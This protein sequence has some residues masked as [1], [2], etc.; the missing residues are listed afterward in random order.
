MSSIDERIVNMD[1]RSN[2][3]VR[4][5]STVL[6]ML[7]K[8]K[9]SLS[10]SGSRNGIDQVQESANRFS[11]AGMQG[12]IQ[13]VSAGFIALSTVAITALSNIVNRAVDAGLSFA[14][15][16]TIGPV[17]D[18]LHE[19]ETNLKSIQTVQA[20]TDRPLP[21]INAALDQLNKYSDQTIY[22]FSEM[23]RNVGTFTA[24]G[25]D[26][27]TSVSSIK[28][29]AN[30]AA[31]SGSSSEQAATAMYQLSQAIASGKVGL[32]DWNSVVNAGMGG[33]KLQNALAQ[34]A[35]AMGTID[36]Q[37][38]KMVGPMKKLEINGQSFRE[39]IMAKPGQE[40]WLSSDILVNT[41]SS[42]DGRF[43]KAALAAEK[44]ETGLRKYSAAQIEAKIQQN[45]L[46]LEQK[47]GV[48]YT[49]EQFKALQK[50]STMAFKSAT[51]VKTLGQVFDIV[52]ETIGSGWAASFRNIFGDLKEA[53]KNFT[54]LKDTF[55]GIIEQN[56]YARNMVLSAWSEGGGRTMVIDGLKNAWQAL[57]AIAKPI[58]EAFRQ[59]FPAK[60][61]A[62]LLA[63]SAAFEK[64][65]Q[66]LIIGKGTA[67]DIKRTFAGVFAIFSIAGQ[68]IGGFIGVIFKLFGVVGQGAGSFLSFTGGIGDFLVGIDQALKKGD[69]LSKFFSGLAN[70]L[71]IPIKIIQALSQGFLN[72]IGIGGAAGGAV[73]QF[74]ERLSGLDAIM[75]NI[76][77]Y[78]TVLGAVFDNLADKLAPIAPA[79]ATVFAGLGD[80]IREGITSGDFSGVFDALNSVLLGGIFVVLKKFLSNGLTLD[81]GGGLLENIS[82]SF[83]Q[84]TGSMAAMQTQIR[85]KTLLTIAAAVALLTVSIVALSLIDS[86]KLTKALTAITVGFGQLLIAMAV[87][88]KIS[89]SAGFVKVPLIAASMILLAG[90][91]VILS[92][93]VKILSTMS[94]AELLKGLLGV[95]VLLGGLALAANL[96]GSAS[97]SMLRAGLAMIPLSIGILLLAGAVKIF[98]S[99]SLAELAQGLGAVAG[100]L[101]IVAT[102]MS[103]MPLSLPITAAGLVLVA[104]ALNGMALAVLI[105]AGIPSEDIAKGLIAI[106]GGLI[107]IALAMSLMP[108]TL[109]ITAAG[110][111]LVS[112]ALNA[113][114]AAALVFGSMSWE[115]LAIAGAAIA[116]MLT[117][118]SLGL[119]AM[120]GSLVGSAALLI[121]AAAL[122]VLTPILITLGTLDIMTIVTGLGAMAAIFLVFGAAAAILSAVIVPMLGLGAA[123]LL[124]GAGLALAGAGLLAIAAAFGIFSAAGL[125]GIAVTSGLIALI[126]AFLVSFA[127]GVA[128][129]AVQLGRSAGQFGQA[130]LRILGSILSAVGAALPKIGAL[131]LKLIQTAL[132]VIKAA[133]PQFLSTGISL[134]LQ[135]ITGVGKNIGQIVSKAVSF[136]TQ[137]VGAIG[138]NANRLAQAGV[139]LIIDLINAVSR[140]IDSNSAELGQAGG[141]LAVAIVQGMANGI[142]NGLS[143]VTNAAAN[144]AKSA[145]N[146]AKSVLGIKSPSREFAKIGR[147]V[148]EGFAKGLVGGLSVT[149]KAI[150]DLSAT[151]KAGL[152]SARTTITS[153]RSRLDG[154]LRARKRNPKAIRAAK[155]AIAQA[156]REE[157]AILRSQQTLKGELRV[158]GGIVDTLSKQYDDASKRL[159][160][161]TAELNDAI[162]VRDDYNKSVTE[163]YDKPPDIDAST[164]L[165][166]YMR[167]LQKTTDQTI[168]FNKTLA[169]LR[170][171]GLNDSTYKQLVAE[172]IEGQRFA[173]RLL[174]GG[175]TAVDEVDRLTLGME[176]AASTL[177]N[178]TSK[179]L[180]QAG[181][182][183]AQGLVNGINSEIAN[184][185]AQMRRIAGVMVGSI[186]RALRI[187]SPSRVFAEVGKF[188]SLGV[189]KGL[190]EGSGKAEKAAADVGN[191][192]LAVLKATM[193]K[194]GDSMSGVGDINP[195]I[196][197]VL[198][199][200]QL[201]KD[202]NKMS[203]LLDTAPIKADVSY[204]SAA[205]ISA[206][207]QAATKAQQ[208]QNAEAAVAA[209]NTYNF[210]QNISSPKALSPIDIYRQTNNQISFAKEALN[211]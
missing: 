203:S 88:I 172:G 170:A 166:A 89:G 46:N 56:A 119:L 73:D 31:L 126:P 108:L 104:V 193:S 163:A 121:A 87:L 33:K 55:T 189:A 144:L 195:T 154:L 110:L 59:I 174:A 112:I 164:G 135:L 186:R 141:R 20:N 188:S 118:L 21:E 69:G 101:A 200:S 85:A 196:T 49:D 129:F 43:S 28:G 63:A 133:F 22:N 127:K 192:S 173:D 84:L 38:V 182:N 206:A 71:A 111:I 150:A 74:G 120:S 134:M 124:L 131:F 103:L 128:G 44:T 159:E 194:M 47:N 3:F 162:K 106:T 6:G 91:V 165:S 171:L 82:G 105:F 64:F 132:T 180:Y 92:V 13:G 146:K 7:D 143:V 202:A 178:D 152:D 77:L 136:I 184:I 12:G 187:K 161:R 24:A 190:K 79:I 176:T 57:L 99:L 1:F 11:L 50:M 5:A 53:K 151:L 72:L 114:A 70:V 16:F 177:G 39:S 76:K 185:S 60:T 142:A 75:Q 169:D 102:A 25:V 179:A 96:M 209:G 62:D 107:G 95:S 65:T 26:L 90:S 191:N 4:G 66:K 208:A 23:A 54:A 181:V 147:F 138:N 98:A 211:R 51:E 140:A 19:Y 148:N 8:L 93:A 10:F 145:L 207:N 48:K 155:A 15:S 52:K 122:A 61:G 42:V 100:T 205:N 81:F 35:I 37:A 130:F 17:I 40:A 125:A 137:F 2:T 94:W 123:M 157:K 199:L 27:E 18:G 109:P 201:Q 113:L 158:R 14:K 86:A 197:P 204:A 29:I 83:E 41:L 153:Q 45:R 32:Q 67:E 117:I 97:G 183:S 58:Q 156:Q 68:I 149:R 36:K 160:T 115:E 198:D 116:G 210:E 80:S 30:L 78:T 139:R 34:T 167:N 175:Q 168:R 9:S